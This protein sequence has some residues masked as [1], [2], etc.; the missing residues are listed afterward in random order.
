MFDLHS[1]WPW[2]GDVLAAG[3][4]SLENNFALG[5]TVFIIGFLATL[6]TAVYI[7]RAH[8]YWERQV[9]ATVDEEVAAP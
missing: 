9:D 6:A 3:E 8:R 7:V 5:L 1:A 2:A 4:A